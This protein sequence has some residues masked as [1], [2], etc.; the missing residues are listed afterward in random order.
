MQRNVLTDTQQSSNNVAQEPANV[1]QE[2]ANVFQ[3]G[4][5]ALGEVETFKRP[6]NKPQIAALQPSNIVAPM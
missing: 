3:T 6:L 1:A 4:K 2:P 5:D